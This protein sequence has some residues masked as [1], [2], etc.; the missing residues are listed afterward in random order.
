MSHQTIYDFVIER[1]QMD[2]V[3]DLL[4]CTVVFVVGTRF[5]RQLVSWSLSFVEACCFM[6]WY[7]RQMFSTL[8]NS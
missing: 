5:M 2:N 7:L 8:T 4:T 6:Y 3:V 1:A